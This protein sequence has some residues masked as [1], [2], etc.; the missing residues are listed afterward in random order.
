ML[1]TSSCDHSSS[2]LWKINH[3]PWV[4]WC[5][6]FFFSHPEVTTRMMCKISLSKVKIGN[7]CWSPHIHGSSNLVMN[8][9]QVGQIANHKHLL[10]H[11]PRNN[12]KGHLYCDFCRNWN[13][14]A[15]AEFS[16]CSPLYFQILHT[17]WLSVLTGD[18]LQPLWFLVE[19]FD[20]F[21]Q[22]FVCILSCLKDR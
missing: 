9:N 2:R 11:M 5:G 4:W 18:F 8:L 7:I 3:Y 21:F 22:N 19:T 14:V 12:F 15:A 1:R 20:K 16:N 6:Q 10:L 17:I 13:N